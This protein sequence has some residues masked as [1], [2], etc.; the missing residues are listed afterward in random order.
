MIVGFLNNWQAH[1]HF[2][3]KLF[4]VA[5][6]FIESQDVFKLADGKHQIIGNDFFV[7]RDTVRTADKIHKNSEIHKDFIDIQ[8]LLSGKESHIYC[9]Q[10]PSIPSLD[11]QFEAKDVAFYSHDPLANVI[12]LTAGQYVIYFPYEQHAPC[13]STE[14]SEAIHKLIFKIRADLIKRDE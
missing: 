13:C 8:V 3:P 11:D 9:S 2:Y 12:N 10:T 14:D 4:D 1:K 5:F 7:I 6:Q